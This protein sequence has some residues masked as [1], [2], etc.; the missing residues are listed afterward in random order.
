[1]RK[2]WNRKKVLG[3]NSSDNY[4]ELTNHQISEGNIKREECTGQLW[5]GMT[6]NS[7]L[8][9]RN[10]L[11]QSLKKI[12]NEHGD[13]IFGFCKYFL[14]KLM[15]Y[16]FTITDEE[17]HYQQKKTLFTVKNNKTNYKKVWANINN[18]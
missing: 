17:S 7:L 14:V 1:M 18:F 8:K 10:I 5:N 13:F 2:D 11:V 15:D 16:F 6:K 9:E 3:L 12:D 4:P